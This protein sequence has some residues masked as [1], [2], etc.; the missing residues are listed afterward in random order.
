MPEMDKPHKRS[1]PTCTEFVTELSKTLKLDRCVCLHVHATGM[2]NGF[3][4]NSSLYVLLNFR[5]FRLNSTLNTI[6]SADLAVNREK[7]EVKIC[8][9]GGT[10]YRYNMIYKVTGYSTAQAANRL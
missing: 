7:S 1:N 5:F 9:S 8:Y 6:K 10:A 2:Q 3:C 4:S